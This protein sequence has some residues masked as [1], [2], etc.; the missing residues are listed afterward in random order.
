V[1]SFSGIAHTLIINIDDSKQ[2]N[3]DLLKELSEKI[4]NEITKKEKI[5]ES[6]RRKHGP[7]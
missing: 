5:L 1:S 3:R 6:M 7:K 2:Q 4:L